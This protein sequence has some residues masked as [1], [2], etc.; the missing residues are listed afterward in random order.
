MQA[1]KNKG[2]VT[3]LILFVVMLFMPTPEGLTQDAWKVAAVVVLMAVWWATEAIPV[4]VTALL[5]LALFPL[6]QITTFKSAALP[7]ANPNIY[8]FLGGFMLAI[9]IERSGLHKRMALK[10]ILAAGSSGMK[11]IGGFMLVA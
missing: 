10:M 9:A 6:F 7:Y 3:G 5:P 2:F 8:L 4:P 11:L 1:Y